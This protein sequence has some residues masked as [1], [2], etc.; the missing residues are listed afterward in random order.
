M[1]EHE[2]DKNID[3]GT[4]KASYYFGEFKEYPGIN[5][6]E[7]K[8]EVKKSV[9]KIRKKNKEDENNWIEKETG[10]IRIKNRNI[11]VIKE[12]WWM[13]ILRK[14]SIIS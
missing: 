9:F 4:P 1:F 14:I 11:K 7:E 3:I 2:I 10:L 6:D 12:K 5:N 8:R 13:R